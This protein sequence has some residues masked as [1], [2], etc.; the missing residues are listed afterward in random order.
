MTIEES[1]KNISF[2]MFLRNGI[3]GNLSFGIVCSAIIAYFMQSKNK[4]QINTQ[5]INKAEV[6]KVKKVKKK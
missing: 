4:P 5:K 2:D 1:Q 6:V 3:S